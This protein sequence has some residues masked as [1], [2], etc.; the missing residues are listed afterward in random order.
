MGMK[1]SEITY[2]ASGNVTACN[3]FVVNLSS[4][5]VL[6]WSKCRR[7]TLVKLEAEV[8]VTDGRPAHRLRLLRLVVV[9]TAV[10]W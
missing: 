9:M 3:D 7:C 8:S 1:G 2:R 5:M 4:C 10:T 6:N